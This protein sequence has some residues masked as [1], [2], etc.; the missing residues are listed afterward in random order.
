MSEQPSNELERLCMSLLE[1]PSVIGDERRI[2]DFVEN[3]VRE[4][5]FHAVT[6]AGDNLAIQPL[7]FREGVPRLL[8]LGHL[9]TVPVSDANPPRVAGDLIHG[10]GS[11][12]MKGGDAVLLEILARAL[13]EEPRY[14]LVGVLYAAEEGPY[15]GSGMPEI[16]SAAPG[17]FQEVDLAVAM[18]PTDNQIELGCLGTMHAKVTF[19][20]KRAHSARPWQGRNA[21]HMAAPLM[22]AIAALEPRDIDHGGLR[23]REVLS[24]TMLDY[25]GA[26]NVIPGKCSFNLNFRFGPDRSSEEAIDWLEKFVR[27]AVGPGLWDAGLVRFEVTDL[28]PSGR[29]CGDNP[30]LAELR[31]AAGDEVQ[32]LAK[33]AWTDVGRLS[34]MGL[35][36]LNFGPGSPSQAHQVGEHL[37][38]ARLAASYAIL[39]RL[40]YPSD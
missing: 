37:S 32:T 6:R 10:L 23:F 29:V 38:R 18:E 12:D 27:D 7:P 39:A 24:V 19:E 3:W 40:L 30:L 31:K 35:D 4:K 15:E 34:Q 14:D 16:I 21:L 22:S 2:A 33:Q 20:G 9:D 36:A 28:C 8:L 5:G 11:S 17:A 13:E 26:R 25:E 1:I